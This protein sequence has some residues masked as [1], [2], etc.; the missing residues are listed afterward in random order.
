MGAVKPKQT[1]VYQNHH[2]D[3]TRWDAIALRQ[4]DIVV[5]TSLKTGTTWTQR[6]VS[7]LLFG[8]G[9][10]P[11]SLNAISPWI[12]AVFAPLDAVQ[13]LIEAQTHR[14][15]FKTHLALDALPYDESVKYVYV[16]RDGR[17]V[18]MSLWN[19][20]GAYNDAIYAL[21]NDPA[22]LKGEPLA[23][24]PSDIHALY[25]EWVGRS[26]FPWEQ[27][28]YPF[29]SHF[30]HAQSFWN[31]RHL[32]NV[33]FVHF[34][35]MKANLEKEMRGIASFLGIDVAE[36]RWPATVEGATFEA[37]KRDADALLPELEMGMTGG[38]KT[39]VNKGTND[40]WRD[41]LT[42]DELAQYDRLVART[43]TPDLARW[44]ERG[45]AAGN[46]KTM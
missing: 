3:S 5:A 35:D 36:P 9:P 26:L 14:R 40:R 23:R 1:R 31:F 20:Y 33:H 12:E 24:C 7:L 43:V 21:L 29:W 41:V 10:L 34:A 22:T 37:M 25:A 6:I 30:Y 8:P 27:D 15:F 18:F 32:P 39:F 2:I 38:A 19:H 13:G 16:G 28:G 17:D 46:P 42:A 45:S 4:G 11:A 44:L